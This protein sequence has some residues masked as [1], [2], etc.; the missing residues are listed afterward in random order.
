MRAVDCRVYIKLSSI[1][2][3]FKSGSIKNL[4]FLG[5][6]SRFNFTVA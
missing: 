6:D 3:W 4:L 1:G 5:I 2:H